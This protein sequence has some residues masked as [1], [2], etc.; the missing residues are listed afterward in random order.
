MPKREA[1]LNA[2]EEELRAS[3]F[4]LGWT[5]TD[6]AAL[7]ERIPPRT[8]VSVVRSLLIRRG[9]LE[10]DVR[11]YASGLQES[12]ENHDDLKRRLGELGKP[13][14]VSRLAIVIRTLREQGDLTGRV[15]IA[16]EALKDAQGL[17]GRRLKNLNPGDID[18]E[19][20]TNIAVPGK[21][22]VQECRERKQD[23]KRRLRETQQNVASVQ[24]QLDAAIAAFDR[25]VRDERVVT[26]E[27]LNEARG[28]RDALWQLVK[29]RHVR[30]EPIPED[31]AGCFEEELENLA[32]AFEPAM[33]R[34][35]DLADRRFDHAEAAGRIAEIKRKIGE[36]E[37]LLEQEKK[38][39]TRL[40]EEGNQLAAEWTSMWAADSNGRS[41]RF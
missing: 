2:A 26:S 5:E 14:D 30:D 27:E 6:S 13:A 24:Q 22:M 10:A 19:T 18:E 11:S 21:A 37:T 3:A 8:Q 31:Q 25:T 4:E 33:V 17:T 38:I 15:R 40:V 23:W 36:Q 1:E 20:L 41:K 39:E 29:L 32:G 12:Q 34:A 9:E 7:I 28:H 16:E 35:D